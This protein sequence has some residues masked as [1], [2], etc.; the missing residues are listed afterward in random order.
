MKSLFFIFLLVGCSL[1]EKK[2]TKKECEELSWQNVGYQSVVN[3]HNEDFITKY[4]EQCSQYGIKTNLAEV[5]KGQKKAIKTF[6]HFNNGYEIGLK[7]QA[8]NKS[9]EQTNNSFTIAYQIG[10]QQFLLNKKI[11]SAES[12]IN[13]LEDEI[14]DLK[15]KK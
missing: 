15:G 4:S 3:T 6:C 11:E 7:G 2:L 12:K 8:Y 1:F 14:E 10:Y 9:C 13:E 5:K